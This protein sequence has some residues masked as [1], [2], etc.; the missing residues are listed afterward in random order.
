[1]R[2]RHLSDAKRNVDGLISNW[3]SNLEKDFCL[4]AFYFSS[5]SFSIARNYLERILNNDR[6][7]DHNL[8]ESVRDDLGEQILGLELD[9]TCDKDLLSSYN[10]LKAQINQHCQE[11]TEL[12]SF[13]SSNFEEMEYGNSQCWIK[14]H[15]S[16]VLWKIQKHMVKVFHK[17]H[18]ENVGE[19]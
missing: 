11:K 7:R 3:E 4:L 13:I 18:N 10:T 19:N 6:D 14:L 1:M 2:Y 8:W 5:N 9:S 17:I 12:Y 15:F 16:L